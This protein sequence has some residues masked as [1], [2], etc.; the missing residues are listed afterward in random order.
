MSLKIDIGCGIK[1]SWHEPEGNPPSGEASWVRV[2]PY[3]EE[4]DL[5]AFAHDLPYKD[6]EVDEIFSSHTLE[7]IS[8]FKI[9][10]TLKE[11]YRVLKPLGKLTVRVPDLEWCCNWWIN[12]QTTGWDMD[13]LFGNQSREG[14]VHL[15]GFNRQIMIDYLREAG[16]KIEKFEE[17]ET[18]DQKT[19]SFECIK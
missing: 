1:E 19:L 18:H 9:A 7:H 8:K 15:T 12:H 11:W 14:E 13:V 16:F 6:G 17:M 3:V 10:E 4:A 2:D 5:K